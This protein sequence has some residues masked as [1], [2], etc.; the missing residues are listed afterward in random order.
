MAINPGFPEPS[1]RR[2]THEEITEHLTG[3]KEDKCL[4]CGKSPFTGS[5]T[6]WNGQARCLTCGATYQLINCKLNAES[7]AEDGLRPEDIIIPYCDCYGIIELLQAY[8]TETSMRVPLGT[9]ISGSRQDDRT[10]LECDTFNKW[11]Y[12][13]RKKYKEMFIDDFKWDMLEQHF[14]GTVP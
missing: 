11:L 12:D 7:L 14:E 10:D 1:A 13:N 5:W 3:V 2:K 9:F 6:D 4:I 8:W